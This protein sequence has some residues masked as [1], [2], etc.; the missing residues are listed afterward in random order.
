MKYDEEKILECVNKLIKI[1]VVDE[2]FDISVVKYEN[3]FEIVRN[4]NSTSNV[5]YKSLNDII[6]GDMNIFKLIENSAREKVLTSEI[7]RAIYEYDDIHIQS[8]IKTYKNFKVL[9]FISIEEFMLKMQ[10]MGIYDE[11]GVK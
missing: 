6:C 2:I 5:G 9:I 8:Y 4:G 7:Y 1:N 10:L 3:R 11:S